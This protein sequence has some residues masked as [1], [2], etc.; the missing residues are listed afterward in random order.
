MKNA[1]MTKNMAEKKMTMWL[2]SK[3]MMMLEGTSSLAG[4]WRKMKTPKEMRPRMVSSCV[5]GSVYGGETA[6]G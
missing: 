1:S 3:A 4:D 2:N 5:V 6:R